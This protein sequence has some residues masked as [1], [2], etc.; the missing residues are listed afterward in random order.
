M[1]YYIKV[2]L[3]GAQ[4]PGA[5]VA[6]DRLILTEE[7]LRVLEKAREE[8]EAKGEIDTVHPSYLG[9]QDPLISAR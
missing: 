3:E 6:Q 2:F 4:G 1:Q 8:K 9:A 5:Q 7:Q